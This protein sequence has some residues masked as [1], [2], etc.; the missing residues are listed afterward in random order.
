MSP[1]PGDLLSL[2]SH[3]A[4]SAV[5]PALLVSV[6]T[7]MFSF[8]AGRQLIWVMLVLHRWVHYVHPWMRARW[9]RRRVQSQGDGGSVEASGSSGSA[10]GSRARAVPPQNG[11]CGTEGGMDSATARC[12]A[13]TPAGDDGGG[14]AASASS[15]QP[16]KQVVSTAIEL[17]V[18]PHSADGDSSGNGSGGGSGGSCRAAGRRGHDQ[19]L[20]ADGSLRRRPSAGG[21]SERASRQGS[22]AA[23]VAE[24][25]AAIRDAGVHTDE[26]VSAASLP[27]PCQA[28]VVSA[29]AAERLRGTSCIRQMTSTKL[30]W[31][32]DVAADMM[33]QCSPLPRVQAGFSLW[34][35]FTALPW[36]VVPFLFGMFIMV[37]ALNQGGWVDYFGRVRLGSRI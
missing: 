2:S 5:T 8:A 30:G 27:S 35:T 29:M 19:E 1:A 15:C 12:A 22:G 32:T 37:E 25:D 7:S 14:I 33:N 31:V 20:H 4:S 13:S 11:G 34:R 28:A 6:Y 21:C 16:S 10:G 18:L 23:G 17:V 24:L 26:P 36:H 3:A 9:G